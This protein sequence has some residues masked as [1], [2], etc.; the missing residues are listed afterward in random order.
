MIYDMAPFLI[1]FVI[2]VLVILDRLSDLA[3]AFEESEKA[4]AKEKA[5]APRRNLYR[6][7]RP[8]M[9]RKKSGNLGH[10]ICAKADGRA[11][12][13]ETGPSQSIGE[14]QAWSQ[15]SYSDFMDDESTASLERHLEK[16]PECNSFVWNLRLN[17]FKDDLLKAVEKNPGLNEL[18][19]AQT[20]N[21]FSE[22]IECVKGTILLHSK[23][24][25]V[26]SKKAL[27]KKRGRSL[28]RKILISV[29]NPRP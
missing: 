11:K 21:S 26:W 9:R 20:K 1:C 14:I 10:R 12:K 3:L 19:K 24:R 29:T 27:K 15:R 18:G 4:R 22:R 5:V 25:N 2:F 28:I 7:L 6:G 17:G 8:L 23:M 16:C 13:L